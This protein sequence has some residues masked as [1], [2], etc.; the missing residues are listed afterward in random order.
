MK[1]ILCGSISFADEILRVKRELGTLGHEKD[2]SV[3]L[4]LTITS[5]QNTEAL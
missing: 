5:G 2:I 3:V 4:S 1:I